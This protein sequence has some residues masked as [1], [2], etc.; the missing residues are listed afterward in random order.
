[1]HKKRRRVPATF[2]DYA[3]RAITDMGI[4]PIPRRTQTPLNSQQMTLQTDPVWDCLTIRVRG[5]C[6]CVTS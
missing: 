2:Q 5:V 4:Y 6:Q 1:M 3:S